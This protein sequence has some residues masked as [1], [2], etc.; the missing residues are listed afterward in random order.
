MP[1]ILERAARFKADGADVVD[2]G[3][4]PDHPFPHLEEAVGALEVEEVGGKAA[5][6]VAPDAQRMRKAASCGALALK[7]AGAAVVEQAAERA[8]AQARRAPFGAGQVGNV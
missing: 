7:V 1:A 3:C 5:P 2:L 8:A 6:S 4:L